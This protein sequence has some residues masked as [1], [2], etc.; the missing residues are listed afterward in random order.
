MTELYRFGVS[1]HKTLIEKFDQYVKYK[2]FNNRS[3]A[4]S[5]LIREELARK[6]LF[7]A[8]Q[9]T[10]VITLVYD[11]HS[12]NINGNLTDTQHQFHHLIISSQHI[13]MDEKNCLEIIIAKG[14][15]QKI[16]LLFD[17]LKAERGMQHA[18]LVPV[19]AVEGTL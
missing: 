15:T 9:M 4:I 17:K 6:E 11:H 1:L 5:C 8:K 13:H 7:S 16:Y 2:Q 18:N 19:V 10:A 3:R 12:R 14:D